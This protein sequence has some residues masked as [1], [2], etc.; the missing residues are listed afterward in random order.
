M[1]KTFFET[2]GKSCT[3]YYKDGPEFLL[4]QPVDDHDLA[5]LDRQMELLSASIPFGFLHIAF[6]ITDWNRE[7]S[8]WEAPPVFGREGFGNGAEETLRFIRE[9]LLESAPR[10]F[11]IKEDI[12]LILGGYSL[13][14]FFSLWAAY[15]TGMFTGIAAVSPSVWFPGW[16]EY[17][18]ARQP[19][20]EYI[21]L[22]LGDKE[23]KARNP[24]MAAVG[25]RIREQRQ[26]LNAAGIPNDLEW[27]EGNHFRD[28]GIRCAKGFARCVKVLRA[29]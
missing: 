9:Q 11:D 15:Q 22:S 14:G 20:A 18:A 8:P 12:P 16:S 4:I 21:Y 13:A 2:G 1:E 10:I 29:R 7:L 17:A 28:P 24:V 5:G 6:K 27:N 25:D 26:L 19:S 23:E 3:A